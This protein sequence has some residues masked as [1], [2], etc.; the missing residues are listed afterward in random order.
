MQPSFLPV[1]T[2][3]NWFSVVATSASFFQ[4]LFLALALKAHIT[5]DDDDGDVGPVFAG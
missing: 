5:G 4:I 1:L 2:G 3:A